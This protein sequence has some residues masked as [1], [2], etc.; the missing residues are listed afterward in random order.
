MDLRDLKVKFNEKVALYHK[1]ARWLDGE[2]APLEKK[3][4]W[5]ATGKWDDLNKE[6]SELVE[7]YELMTG[8]NITESE[9]MQ[10]FVIEKPS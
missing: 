9:I 5:L 4:T 10:G 2:S 1:S 6:L 3:Q 8:V 7:Q